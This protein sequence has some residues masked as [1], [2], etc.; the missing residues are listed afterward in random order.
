MP[1]PEIT[2][3]HLE[4]RRSERIVWLMEELN[5]PYR[6]VFRQGE[7]I[8]SMKMLKAANPDMPLAPTV[9]IGDLVM[10][11]SAAIIEVI[12]KR[13]APGQLC[14]PEAD[15]DYPRH[16]MWMSYAE[17][18]LAARVFADYRAWRIKPPKS[19]SPLVDS[20]A[21][22]QFADKYLGQHPWFGGKQ[23][24]AADIMMYLPLEAATSLNVVNASQFP[25]V[26]A[27]KNN[28]Q[29]R[30]AF[31]RMIGKAR[32]NGMVGALPKLRHHAPSG[33][34]SSRSWGMVK[35]RLLEVLEKRLSR[36]NRNPKRSSQG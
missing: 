23:F 32:P 11:E 7:L 33:P 35:I 9:L 19:R 21:V 24:T 1:I 17:G 31:Q 6:L 13:F 4:G 2:I 25:N 15:E 36:S 29:S 18:T 8:G 12:L 28:V 26:A 14:P 27:W 20:Q 16:V 30:P 22:V 5:L 10:V 34:R 3:Y